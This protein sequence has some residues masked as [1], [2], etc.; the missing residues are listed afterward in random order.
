MFSIVLSRITKSCLHFRLF[1]PFPPPAPTLMASVYWLWICWRF[2]SL[3]GWRGDLHVSLHVFSQRIAVG[4][5]SDIAVWPFAMLFIC[6]L[7]LGLLNSS[8]LPTYFRIGCVAIWPL[9]HP[10][11]SPL[12]GSLLTVFIPNLPTCPI[13]PMT[14]PSYHHRSQFCQPCLRFS[15]ESVGLD[16]LW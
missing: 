13:P 15:S 2:R 16:P 7:T 9:C 3:V 12:T 6:L 4:S 8:P 14:S 1:A 5:S 11:H 10:V